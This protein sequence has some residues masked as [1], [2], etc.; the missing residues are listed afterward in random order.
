M[1]KALHLQL[2]DYLTEFIAVLLLDGTDDSFQQRLVVSDASHQLGK[3]AQ[4]GSLLIRLREPAQFNANSHALLAADPLADLSATLDWPV[5]SLE[6]SCPI[7]AQRHTRPRSRRR[8]ST[9]LSWPCT[10]TAT[11]SNSRPAL[12]SAYTPS[13][14]IRFTCSC[15]PQTK[16]CIEPNDKAGTRTPSTLSRWQSRRTGLQAGKSTLHIRCHRAQ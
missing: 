3:P 8:Y 1:A 6:S 10:S 4:V 13:T 2:F 5:M 14:G 12:A 15:A 9:R 7:S 16:L 11:R